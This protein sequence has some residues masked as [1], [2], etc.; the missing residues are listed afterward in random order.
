MY[1]CLSTVAR[2]WPAGQGF[3]MGVLMHSEPRR[4]KRPSIDFADL[5]CYIIVSAAIMFTVGHMLVSIGEG[6]L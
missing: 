4:Y 5:L 6:R 2:G 1:S 3:L